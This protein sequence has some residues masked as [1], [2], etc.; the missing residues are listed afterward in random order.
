MSCYDRVFQNESDFLIRCLLP[1][2]KIPKKL[3]IL[4]YLCRLKNPCFL[5]IFEASLK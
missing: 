3:L 4:A 1:I 5:T 2:S